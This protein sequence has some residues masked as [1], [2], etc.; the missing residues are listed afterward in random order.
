MALVVHIPGP[1]RE[2][3]GGAA[4]VVLESPVSTAG[5]ALDVLFGRHPG[6]RDRVMTDHGEVRQHVNVFVDTESIRHAGGLATPV[7][8]AR[9]LSIVPA[10]SGGITRRS[11]ADRRMSEGSAPRDP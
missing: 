3:T 2:H 9:E 8:H 4:R 11:D 7:A 10:V 6:L 5:E 1:L